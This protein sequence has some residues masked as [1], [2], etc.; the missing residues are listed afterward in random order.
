MPHINFSQRVSE[1]SKYIT[2][3][4]LLS[5]NRVDIAISQI[6]PHDAGLDYSRLVGATMYSD[7]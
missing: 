7:R 1:N 2:R 6:N 3:S 4:L 5:R